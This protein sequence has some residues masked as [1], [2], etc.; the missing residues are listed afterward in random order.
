[1]SFGLLFISLHNIV[2]LLALWQLW[3]IVVA[4]KEIIMSIDVTL[5]AIGI[6]LLIIGI[7]KLYQTIKIFR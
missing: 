2:V 1:L 3:G 5:D 4:P 7:Y 6:I